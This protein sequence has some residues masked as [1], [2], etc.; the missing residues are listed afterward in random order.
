LVAQDPEQ[1]D[2]LQRCLTVIERQID[3]KLRRF[4]LQ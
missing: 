2:L 3:K 1:L 4:E